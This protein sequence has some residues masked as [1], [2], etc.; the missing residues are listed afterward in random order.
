MSLSRRA[1]SMA[2]R[3]GGRCVP[4]EPERTTRTRRD[5]DLPL[6]R[7]GGR[8]PTLDETCPPSDRALESAPGRDRRDENS[9]R[10]DRCA[11]TQPPAPTTS[12]SLVP[13]RHIRQLRAVPR[14][15][16][17]RSSARR[18]TLAY[19][20]PPGGARLLPAPRCGWA[21][22]RRGKTTTDA[23]ALSFA[24]FFLIARAKL[25][26]SPGPDADRRPRCS[27]VSLPLRVD[28]VA[29]T[30]TLEAVCE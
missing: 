11:R 19:T 4:T 6:V 7:A 20:G 23:S 28:Q 15:R 17:R 21:W 22:K 14:P 16:R 10:L 2:R 9:T 26:R 3:D 8:F 13:G 30:T 29:M 12:P 18:A 24:S 27:P 25:E 5:A 1:L